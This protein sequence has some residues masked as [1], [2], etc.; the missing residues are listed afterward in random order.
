[1]RGR[2][3][4]GAAS[5]APQGSAGIHPGGGRLSLAPL[6]PGGAGGCHDRA[7]VDSNLD[8]L[9][10]ARST[11]GPRAAVPVG[12]PGRVPTSEQGVPAEGAQIVGPG[13]GAGS[14]LPWTTYFDEREHAPELRWPRSTMVY[15]EKIGRAHV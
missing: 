11:P 2:C 13:L 15:E 9:R 4:A 12:A 14:V 8:Q 7:A 1:M 3:P 6:A 5:L 10:G